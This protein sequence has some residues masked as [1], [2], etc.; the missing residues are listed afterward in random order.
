S[1]SEF[2]SELGLVGVIAQTL[3]LKRGPRA[4]Q[5][6]QRIHKSVIEIM[7]DKVAPGQEPYIPK[8]RYQGNALS[9]EVNPGIE[10]WGAL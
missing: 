8:A 3:K 5:P 7:E 2:Y 6:G 4:I 9:P 10:P 1:Y